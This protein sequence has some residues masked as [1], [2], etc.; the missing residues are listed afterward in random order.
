MQRTDYLYLVEAAGARYAGQATTPARAL[1]HWFGTHNAALNEAVRRSVGES[2]WPV[3]R[4]LPLPEPNLEDLGNAE[5]L[6]IEVLR[7]DERLRSACCNKSAGSDLFTPVR[8]DAGPGDIREGS[9]VLRLA[10]AHWTVPAEGSPDR[11]VYQLLAVDFLGIGSDR[12][13]PLGASWVEV[14]QSFVSAR[15]ALVVAA[16]LEALIQ[17]AP[18]LGSPW[19]GFFNHVSDFMPGVKEL[20][21]RGT[22]TFDEL[23][24]TLRAPFVLVNLTRDRFDERGAIGVGLKESVIR[25]R[26]SQWWDKGSRSYGGLRGQTLQHAMSAPQ[27]VRPKFVVATTSGVEGERVVLAAWPLP[28]QPFGV[29]DGKLTFDL[30][31]PNPSSPATQRAAQVIGTRLVDHV[32]DFGGKGAIWVDVSGPWSGASAEHPAI[33]YQPKSKTNSL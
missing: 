17:D 28:D 16:A 1:D 20:P 32:A 15:N 14:S 6:L 11:A 21:F 12:P 2:Q 30:A 25:A 22:Q 5:K 3:L 10:W 9:N 8:I 19:T 18:L 13:L 23:A 4:I 29:E 26:A 33:H 27:S 31:A 24:G 7:W